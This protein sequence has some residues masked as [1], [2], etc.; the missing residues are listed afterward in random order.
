MKVCK[1]A[2]PISL[3]VALALSSAGLAQVTPDVPAKR[4]DAIVNLGTKEGAQIVAAQ[5]RYSDAQIVDAN[6]N[7]AGLDLKPSGPPSKT[8][9]ISPKAGAADYNDSAW[10]VID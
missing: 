8:H 7:Y 2:L 3:A 4:A 9:D 5:W 6:H 1:S 10:S